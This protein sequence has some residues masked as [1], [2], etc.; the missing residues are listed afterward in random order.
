MPTATTTH[1]LPTIASAHSPSS[2]IGALLRNDELDKEE[3]TL[4]Q[5]VKNVDT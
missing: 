1:V 2:A 3:E 4:V 5:V